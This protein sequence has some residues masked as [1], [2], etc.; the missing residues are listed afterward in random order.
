MENTKDRYECAACGVF[1]RELLSSGYFDEFSLDKKPIRSTGELQPMKILRDA[2]GYAECPRCGSR[3]DFVEGQP[4]R[5]VD[6]KPDMD[7]VLDHFVCRECNSV[8]R[9]IVNTEY[10]QWFEK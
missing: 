2:N 4:V 9:R 3:M 5:I 10:F 6:G 1:Y 7:N 8:Y